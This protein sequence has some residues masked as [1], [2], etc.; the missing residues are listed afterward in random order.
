M[1]NVEFGIPGVTPLPPVGGGDGLSGDEGASGGAFAT[2]FEEGGTVYEDFGEPVT[3]MTVLGS[4][5]LNASNMVS[6]TTK[7]QGSPSWA[8]TTVNAGQITYPLSATNSIITVRVYSPDKGIPVRLKL[9]D[10]AD[11]TH[12]VETEA[13]TTSFDGWETLTFD[14][15]NEAPGTAPLDPSYTYDKMSIFF[16]FGTDGDTAGE[17]TYLWDTVEFD[18]IP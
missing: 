7:P 16:N 17:K 6:I 18:F 15:S 3:A 4:D 1:D 13:V 10:A 11:P 2:S 9:E 14:F 12:S 8:G 5:P